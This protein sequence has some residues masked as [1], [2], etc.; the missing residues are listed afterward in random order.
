MNKKRLVEA[1]SKYDKKKLQWKEDRI[2]NYLR[3]D[4]V[5]S[6]V[7]KLLLLKGFEVRTIMRDLR[8]DSGDDGGYLISI[9]K[10]ED[11]YYL[12]ILAINYNNSLHTHCLDEDDW[13]EEKSN[14]LD[15]SN[16]AFKDFLIFQTLDDIQD[17]LNEF[18]SDMDRILEDDEDSYETFWYPEEVKEKYPEFT[19]QRIGFLAACL[20]A[21]SEFG[22]LHD[23]ESGDRKRILNLLKED[24]T[25][26]YKLQANLF[27]LEKD[28]QRALFDSLVYKINN[29]DCFK[30]NADDI[31]RIVCEISDTYSF[32]KRYISN[33]DNCIE[34][35]LEGYIDAFEINYENVD[36]KKELK[37]QSCEL[38]KSEES[39]TKI[40]KLDTIIDLLFHNIIS[41][42]SNYS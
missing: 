12:H 42:T 19:R 26:F 22:T 20:F 28:Y 7:E 15:N 4:N 36:N 9:S 39:F 1:L 11:L 32:H 33:L 41:L 34:M 2:S 16:R 35:L 25:E 17:Y 30:F 10:K 37:C 6:N 31:N 13:K 23:G 29:P 24:N 5:Y 27:K 8:G 14:D 3:A 21:Y 18:V 38:E 40:Y